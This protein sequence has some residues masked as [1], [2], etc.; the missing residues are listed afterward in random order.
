[1]NELSS[2]L[3][4][5]G[6]SLSPLLM[7][8]AVGTLWGLTFSF[9]K[10][11]SQAGIGPLAYGFWQTTG[12]GCVVLLVCLVRRERLRLDRPHLIYYLTCGFLALAVPNLILQMVIGHVPAG[13]TAIVVTTVPLLTYALA[14]IVKLDVLSIRRAL[15]ILIG[16][17]GSL[18]L[19]VPKASL[20][21][22]AM[23][24]WVAFG[25]VAPLFYAMGNV[26]VAAHRPASPALPLA[27]GM[28]W[29]A[30]C[31]QAPVIFLTGSF[32]MLTIPFS[33]GEWGVLGQIAVSSLASILYFEIMRRA[34]PVFFSQVAYVVTLTAILW[35]MAIFGERHS[36]LVWAAGALIASGVA[37]VNWRKG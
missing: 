13:V 2:T 32:Q 28:L 21:E 24:G 11:A 6:G 7:L 29:G 22:P 8:L 1:M 36:L 31:W 10:A 4:R 3:S 34:G 37:L 20:P 5:A 19:V 17:A 23:V 35:A 18:L 9:A 12:A 30:A 15:G 33:F 14:M 26:Y 16:L 25:F 27:A